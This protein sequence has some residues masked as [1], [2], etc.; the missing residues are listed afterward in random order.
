M[1]LGWCLEQAG[2]NALSG[3]TRVMSDDSTGYEW[4]MDKRISV[5]T[6]ITLLVQFAGFVWFTSSINSRVGELESWRLSRDGMQI[7]QRLSIHAAEIATLHQTDAHFD[8]QLDRME[9]KL[10]A[11]LQQRDRGKP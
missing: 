8:K 10:D 11:L 5:A 2:R 9:T 4:R 3:S 7:E 6:L 1:G